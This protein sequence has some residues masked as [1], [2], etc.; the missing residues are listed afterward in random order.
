MN[1]SVSQV[2]SWR[3]LIGMLNNHILPRWGSSQLTDVQVP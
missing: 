1:L 2:L 3:P